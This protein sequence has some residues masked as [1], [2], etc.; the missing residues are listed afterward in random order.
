MITP[1]IPLSRP[2]VATWKLDAAGLRIYERRVV[3]I[4]GGYDASDKRIT[5]RRF[6]ITDTTTPNL[7]TF[8]AAC[9]AG[10]TFKKQAETFG[11]TLAADLAG[12]VT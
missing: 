2:S 11:A 4:Y 12:D 7:Q 3:L 10:P 6:E 1:A 5:E 9:P 8:I